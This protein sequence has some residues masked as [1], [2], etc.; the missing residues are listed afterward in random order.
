MLITVNRNAFFDTGVY[1]MRVIVEL[2]TNKDERFGLFY[3]GVRQ[4]VVDLGYNSD[5]HEMFEA[6][7]PVWTDEKRGGSLF[8]ELRPAPWM[9]EVLDWTPLPLNVRV[10]SSTQSSCVEYNNVT[11]ALSSVRR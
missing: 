9:S 4:P 8:Y 5:S 10:S 3:K 6:A 11:V 7:L 1:P 2:C